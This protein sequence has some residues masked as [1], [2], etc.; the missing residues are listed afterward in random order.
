[1]K[2]VKKFTNN[3]I[4]SNILFFQATLLYADFNTNS[5]HSIVNQSI[6]RILNQPANHRIL[7]K[8][9]TQ[10]ILDDFINYNAAKYY[11]TGFPLTIQCENFNGNNAV[12]YNSGLHSKA[13]SEL[14]N[15]SS[16][17]QIGSNSKSFLSVVILQLEAESRLSLDDKVS[18]YLPESI[19]PKWANITVKQ[20]LNMTSG[21]H[22]YANDEIEILNKVESNPYQLITTDEILNSVKD[23][24][25][26]FPSGTNWRYSNTNYVIAGKIIEIIT[27]KSV[28]Q[29]ITERIIKPLNLQHTYYVTTFEK[30]NVLSNDKNNL[31]SG[32]FGMNSNLPPHILLGTDIIDYS[33]SWGNAAGSII[34]TTSDLNEYVRALFSDKL[35]NKSQFEKLISLVD[36][37]TGISLPNS[38]N[39]NH[40]TGY[41]LGIEARYIAKDNTV[42]Y[43]HGG[44]TLGFVSSWSYI[45]K[46]KASFI[47][48]FNASMEPDD[49]LMSFLDSMTSSF[50]ESCYN[51]MPVLQ[52]KLTEKK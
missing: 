6:S 29:E 26:W 20:L 37:K 24:D 32:Y 27:G 21:I 36:N 19:Y 40:P 44:G 50:P 1:M 41:G 46:T 48:S 28:A 9:D 3:S 22:D 38:V 10:K 8:S 11:V 47:F 15:D 4:L 42:L 52:N 31:M 5:E 30:D 25:L 14:V 18:K 7:M 34:S 45:P 23:F 39:I 13:G 35:L 17:W 49:D 33:M 16:I 12:T 43:S 2:Y 51:A